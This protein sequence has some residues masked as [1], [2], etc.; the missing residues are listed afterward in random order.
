MKTRKEDSIADSDISIT[1]GP[2]S[3]KESVEDSDDEESEIVSEEV[4]GVGKT[5]D[6]TSDQARTTSD[7]TTE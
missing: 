3:D 7:K 2:S 4:K 6:Q 5:S 1:V